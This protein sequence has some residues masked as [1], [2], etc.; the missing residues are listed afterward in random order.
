MSLVRLNYY[1]SIHLSQGRRQKNF[2]RGGQ[3][4]KD[5][6][7]ALL[8][9]YLLYLC[10]IWKSRRATPPAFDLSWT[11][12]AKFRCV[13]VIRVSS[14]AHTPCWVVSRQHY[15]VLRKINKRKRCLKLVN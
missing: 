6:K 10:H 14:N 1:K 7:I 2:Q 15:D 12:C 9:L 5:L 8:R 13:R 4:K 11:F 3:R